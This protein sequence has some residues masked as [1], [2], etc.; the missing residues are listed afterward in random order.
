MSID[1][2]F[3][4]EL[5]NIILMRPG[6]AADIAA[7]SNVPGY[8]DAIAGFVNS[9][10]ATTYVYPIIDL[11]QAFFAR[12]PDTDGFPFWVHALEGGVSLQSI[13]TSFAMVWDQS[14]TNT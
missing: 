5:Y 4:Q 7:W 11:Y 12:I 9:T 1:S 14:N 2:K 10:E 13:A 8:D 3:V 6:S